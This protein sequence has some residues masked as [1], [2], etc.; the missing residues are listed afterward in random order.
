MN[1][2]IKIALLD[3]DRLFV[4]GIAALLSSNENFTVVYKSNNPVDFTEYIQ[5]TN[6]LPDIVIIDLNMKPMTGIE[7]LAII[8]EFDVKII[9]LSSL[10]NSSMYGYMIKFGISAFLPKYTDIEELYNAIEVVHTN[11]IFMNKENE[12][13]LNEFNSNQKKNLN[14][15]NNNNLSE[16]E[17]EVLTCVC[18][19]MSTKEIAEH[20]FISVKTVESHRAKIMEKIGC[21]NLIGMVVYG[22]LNGIVALK[23]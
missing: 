21:K 15:W 18:K 7:V 13:L 4:E 6:K 5:T 16:R 22:F 9:V 10:F 3:D 19:E 20:L 1:E 14:P 11:K 17:I 8:N 23:N 2:P 12:T